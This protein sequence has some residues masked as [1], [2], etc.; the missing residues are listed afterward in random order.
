MIKLSNQ[1]IMPT[2]DFIISKDNSF[3]RLKKDFVD[4]EK[5][6][7]IYKS[8]KTNKNKVFNF[9]YNV[10]K[11][12]SKKINKYIDNI[13]DFKIKLK[14]NKNKNIIRILQNDINFEYAIDILLKNQ[15]I[16]KEL[17]S[18]YGVIRSELVHY[19]ETKNYTC[20]E[21]IHKYFLDLKKKEKNIKF[22]EKYIEKHT[23]E[24]ENLIENLNVKSYSGRSFF[25]NNDENSWKEFAESIKFAKF[26]SF[27]VV[28]NKDKLEIY[29]L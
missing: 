2:I 9:F 28:E 4:F 25:I 17:I 24:F 7:E 1:D 10:L 16:Y 6:L 21:K 11:E 27:S 20:K 26:T 3:L 15:Q 14:E 13:D 23:E 18:D 29:F 5:E 19:K 22:L 12:D 8:N